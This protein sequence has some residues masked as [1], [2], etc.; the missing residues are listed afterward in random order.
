M[1]ASVASVI[2]S[3]PRAGQRC[4]LYNAF[5]YACVFSHLVASLVQARDAPL[6]SFCDPIEY[7]DA[8]DM[9]DLSTWSRDTLQAHLE[10][11]HR[12]Q[13]PYTNANGDDVWK[14]LQ[15]VDAG[16]M[17]DGIPTV[18]LIYSQNVI[19]AEPKGTPDT[20]NREH[21][22]PKS[23]GVENSGEDFTDIHH[24]FPEDWGVNSIRNNRFFDWCNSTSC[25]RL[26]DDQL[27]G[28]DVD[29]YFD[30]DLF[31]PPH[32]ARGDVA[33]ALFYMAVRYPYLQLTDCPDETNDY[34]MAYPSTLQWHALDPPS[35]K[36]RERNDRVCSRWQGNRNPFV[37]FP[38]LV[39]EL[40]GNPNDKPF[41]CDNNGTASVEDP[42]PA[43]DAGTN[44]TTTDL[45]AGDIMIV[46]IQSDDPDMVAMVALTN[47]SA[48]ITIHIS[49]N[50]WDGISFYT[51]EGT[52]SLTLPHLVSAGT[53][54]GY[55]DD[56]LFGTMWDT[57]TDAGFAL[58]T[59]GDTVIVW[60]S[61][62]DGNRDIDDP[63]YFR[64]LSALSYSGPWQAFGQSNYET[65]KSALPTSLEDFSV[66]LSHFDNY[67][68][69]GPVVGTKSSLQ[70]SLA[71]PNNWEGTNTLDSPSILGVQSHTFEITDGALRLQTA[72]VNLKMVLLLT[73]LLLTL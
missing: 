68:Y 40:F 71:D 28:P 44:K 8:F 64:F 30:N 72:T 63:S 17:T 69:V 2:E 61:L 41:G 10:E 48:G 53:I 56:L 27:A 43:P 46:A 70:G 16:E 33:R 52:I 9:E 55:G 73:L 39:K 57:K 49:D 67:A 12:K 15:D 34:E 24:L 29:T 42:T 5:I 6:F 4:W 36:E 51:N 58:A 18:R 14:A 3:S 31:Q 25:K 45:Q 66:G 47:L 62:P 23:R 38:D 50:A 35:D 59:A 20:W 37:D 32:M 22:W 54:F 7:Y 21:C 65:S 26:S 13:L 11:T 60:Y 1:K 19:P